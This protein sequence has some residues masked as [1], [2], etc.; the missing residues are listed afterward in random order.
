MSEVLD[1]VLDLETFGV[2]PQSA[3]V[4]IGAVSLSGSEFYAV[5]DSP[6]GNIEAGSVKWWLA[7][8]ED[9]RAAITDTLAGCVAEESEVLDRF[10]Q[11]VWDLRNAHP[12]K[13]LRVWGSEDFDTVILAAA[14]RRNDMEPPWGYQEAR[15][16]RTV[17]DVLAV[18]EDAIPWAGTE[19]IAI[20]CARHAAI[21]LAAALAAQPREIQ[22]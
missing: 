12:A 2:G 15:G 3:V 16:L 18:D 22:R 9:V 5:I 10:G 7:Q 19:H 6:S 1:I 17:F 11:W 21:A 14:Y 4:S 20:E 8:A 13:R